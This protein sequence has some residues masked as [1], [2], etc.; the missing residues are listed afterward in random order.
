MGLDDLSRVRQRKE[1]SEESRSVR[2]VY[3][4]GEFACEQTVNEIRANHETT[5]HAR[6]QHHHAPSTLPSNRTTLYFP[7]V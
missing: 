6:L 3:T 2:D 5:H 7:S 4:D 1:S